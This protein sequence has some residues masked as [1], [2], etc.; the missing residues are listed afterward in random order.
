MIGLQVRK[1]WMI[2][3][4]TITVVLRMRNY[5]FSRVKFPW[6]TNAYEQT[7]LTETISVFISTSADGIDLRR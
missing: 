4:T 1:V 5:R 2:C 3:N 7:G 6:P